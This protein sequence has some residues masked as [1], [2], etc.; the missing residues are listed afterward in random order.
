GILG[1]TVP[2]EYGGIQTDELSFILALEEIGRALASLSVIVSV[3]CSLFCYAINTF[4]TP[5][6][7]DKYLP[8]AASG[9]TLGAF[10]LTEPGAGSDATQLKTKAHKDGDV[11]VLNG[12][13]SWVTNG[14]EANA[15]ILFAKTKQDKEKK[16]SAF[17]VDKDTPGLQVTRIEEKLGLHASPTAE[18]TL[19]DCCIPLENLLGDEGQGTTIAFQCLDHSRIGIAAQSVG[20]AQRALD[21]TVKYAKTREAFGTTLSSLQAIQFMISDIATKTEAA[22]LLTYQAALLFE[23]GKS[24]AKESSM[25]KLYASEAANKIAYLALQIHGGYGYSKEYIVEQLF[26]DARA[27]SIYEGTSEIQRLV[28]SRYLLKE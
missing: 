26:R 17:I 14:R 1:M 28:I 23:K 18:I 21:E 11:Y 27:F 9:Q 24:F 3:H 22:R 7:K 16:F 10:S 2:A 12:T 8:P 19:E 20:L 5:S 6:Q 25:A 15:L 4:G 13:K